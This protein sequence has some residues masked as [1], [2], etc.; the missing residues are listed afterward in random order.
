M[1]ELTWSSFVWDERNFPDPARL[2]KRIKDKGIRVCLWI[3]PYIA[4]EGAAFAEA[5]AKG[6]LLL[7]PEGDVFQADHW[8][9]GVGFVG[10]TG[11]GRSSGKRRAMRPLLR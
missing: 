4:E 9:P 10:E 11:C 8:Q 2:L 6:Y 7:T 1:R 5:A 3:N